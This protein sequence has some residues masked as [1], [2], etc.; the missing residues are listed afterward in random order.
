MSGLTEGDRYRFLD[1]NG[2]GETGVDLVLE[3]YTVTARWQ[4]EKE[5]IEAIRPNLQRDNGDVELID[6][7]G[8]NV[9]VQMTG[10][11]AGCQMAAVTLDGIELVAEEVLS[12]GCKL[13][14]GPGGPI[15]ATCTSASC[16]TDGS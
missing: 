2:T 7:D 1:P 4:Q 9:Y 14:T 12:V 8:K 6:V 15:G 10:A 11:C 3:D 13:S 5:A 16:F